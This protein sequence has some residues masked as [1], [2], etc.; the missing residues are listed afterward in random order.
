[1][2]A[3]SQSQSMWAVYHWLI[4]IG[5]SSVGVFAAAGMAWL[6]LALLGGPDQTITAAVAATVISGS[7]GMLA[8]IAGVACSIM[9]ARDDRNTAWVLEAVRA[10]GA[11]C[12][13]MIREA[14]ESLRDEARVLE[15]RVTAMEAEVGELRELD[16]K[17]D[18]LQVL[19]SVFAGAGRGQLRALDSPPARNGRDP[20]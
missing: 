1:M 16:A 20:G 14:M 4:V 18:D 7:A 8:L 19:G 6:V 3:E 10:A 5:G 13:E 9:C 15:K 17:V 12:A 2:T 11:E